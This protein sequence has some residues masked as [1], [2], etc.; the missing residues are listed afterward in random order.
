[1]SDWMMRTIKA[2]AERLLELAE[3]DAQLRAD[4]RALAQEIL[5]GTEPAPEADPAGSTAKEPLRELTLGQ[6]RPS[7][8]GEARAAESPARRSGVP[9][10]PGAL[11]G[12][13]R[14][15]AEAARWVA[16]RQRRLRERAEV[17]D[18]SSP[19]DAEMTQWAERL[20]NGFYWFSSKV[21][22]TS[23]EVTILDEVAGSFEAVA[24]SL[25]LAGECPG[26]SK[27]LSRSLQLVAEAQSALRRSLLRLEISDDPDQEDVYEWLRA[28][29]AKARVY[30]RR[31]MRADDLA[32]PA[33]WPTLVSQIEQARTSGRK[34]PLQLWK[35]ELIRHHEAL[36]LEGK[37]SETNWAAIIDAIDW[38]IGSGI[39]PSSREIREL[40]LAIIDDVPDRENHP[41]NFL[42]VIREIDRYLATRPAASS[43]PPIPEPAGEIQEVAR[44]LRGSTI[45]LIGGN[46]RRDSQESLL[47]AFGLDS[48]IWIE[49]REHQSVHT[50]EPQIARPEVALVLLAI[51]WSSHGFGEVRY[52]CES[53]GKPLVRLPG[54]YSPNQVAAQILAQCSE[55]LRSLDPSPTA[56]D[57]D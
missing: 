54:G 45:V 47:R 38:L 7:S 31:H 4:L 25:A 22:S 15:K 21:D 33:G 41:E 34:S 24:E 5:A 40:V 28:K 30:L 52:V 10:D 49:T 23:T 13:C 1:M 48:V 29:A 35:L 55:Q 57:P 43:A 18:E 12:R 44:L 11:E 36:I 39:P 51:R 20:T 16:E 14:Q 53:H 19:L 2:E 9:L 42:R 46:R 8:A 56:A 6:T 27:A 17:L 37:D 26:Q 32:D 50:F 3:D